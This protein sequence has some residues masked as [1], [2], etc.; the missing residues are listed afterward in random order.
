MS[1][2]SRPLMR[3]IGLAAAVFLTGC[4]RSEST[5]SRPS[6]EH[7]NHQHDGDHEHDHESHGDSQAHSEPESLADAVAEIERL[8]GAI[9][10]GFA[11][12]DLDQADGPVH[13]IGHLIE[14]LP[15]LAAKESVSEED[16]QQVKQ[17]VDSL[18]D[19]FAALDERV[20]GGASAGK[21]YDDVASQVD[22]AMAIL[23]AIEPPEEQP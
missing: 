11:A 10:Q 6:G 3:C 9:D 16:Q 22:D 2:T 12:G 4:G 18:M 13:E 17:A 7:G 14:E 19:S 15:E 8:R 23:R 5:V 21:S 20:H 1:S